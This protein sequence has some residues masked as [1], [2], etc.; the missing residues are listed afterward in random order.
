MANGESVTIRLTV[1]VDPDHLTAITSSGDLVSQ[2]ATSGVGLDT[3]FVARDLSDDPVNSAN[4]ELDSTPDGEGDDPNRHRFSVVS[5][6]KEV[7]G[8]A[9][10]ALS[11]V[12]GNYDVTYRLVMENDGSTAL[13]GLQLTEDLQTQFGASFVG[14]VGSPTILSAATDVP[15]LSVSYTGMVGNAELFAASSSRLE[16]NETV[17]VMLTVEVDADAVGGIRQASTGALINQATARAED[18]L[19]PG[20]SRDRLVR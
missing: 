15:E 19:R 7:V 11:G 18:P 9:T 1:E 16:V 4:T 14:L 8:V 5:L 2:V 13:V 10:P 12:Q 6:S 17:T 20:G 3:A